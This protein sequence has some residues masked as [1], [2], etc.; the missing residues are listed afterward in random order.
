M[1]GWMKAVAA[2]CV[3]AACGGKA[4]SEQAAVDTGGYGGVAGHDGGL[5]GDGGTGDAGAGGEAGQGASAGSAGGGGST[6]PV[7]C[8]SANC[9]ANEFC[10]I[11]C[12]GV[13]FYC[14]APDDAGDCGAGEHLTTD[15]WHGPGYG[16]DGGGCSNVV[17]QYS[18]LPWNGET[19]YGCG[20]WGPVPIND[21]EA[22][23]CHD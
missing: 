10:L 11:S 18:C 9:G 23:C 14:S 12:T 13:P 20:S 6:T 4:V 1:T 19:E 21:R 8:G 2:A 16:L 5:G 15:C 7:A 3:L 17:Y 22:Q